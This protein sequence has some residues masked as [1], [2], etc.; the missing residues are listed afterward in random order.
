MKRFLVILGLIGMFLLGACATTS[1]GA[2]QTHPLKIWKHNE[3][4]EASTWCLVDE[5]TGVNYI[6]VTTELYEKPGAGAITP[7]LNAD[8]SLYVTP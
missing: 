1:V 2:E 4:G 8:G 5:D 7:R 6:V 3:N